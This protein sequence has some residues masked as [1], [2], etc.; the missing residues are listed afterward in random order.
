MRISDWSSDVCSSDLPKRSHFR[1]TLSQTFNSF[2]TFIGPLI[3][4]HLFLQGV[5]VKEGAVVTE[6]VRKQA[7]AGI[8]SAYF[9][10][11]GLIAALFLFF[12]ISRRIVDAPVAASGGA[13]YAHRF[14]RVR[15]VDVL[16]DFS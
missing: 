15:P 3:G 11:C 2:G 12:W 4:A 9:W 14:R 1:L 10:I 5:E 7:L 8:D 6:A 16:S 13:A